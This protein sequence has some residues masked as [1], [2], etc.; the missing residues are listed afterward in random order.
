VT[1]DNAYFTALI[2]KP[3]LEPNNPMADHIGL[4]SDHALPEDPECLGIIKEYASDGG[5]FKR[6]FAAAYAKLAGT[7]VTW[8][9]A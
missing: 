1:F 4:P 6:D 9:E 2:A 5:A 8:R 3:W 7:G